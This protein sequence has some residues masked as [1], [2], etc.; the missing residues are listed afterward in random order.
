ML[1]PAYGRFE[2]EVNAVCSCD[3]HR[4]AVSYCIEPIFVIQ[5]FRQFCQSIL[6]D[7]VVHLL[8]IIHMYMYMYMCNV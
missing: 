7:K 5:K 3:C 1:V 6:F 4:A 8:L 2:I